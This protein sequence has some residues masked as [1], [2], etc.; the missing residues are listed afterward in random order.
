MGF[1]HFIDPYNGGGYVSDF[2]EAIYYGN[3]DLAKSLLE[4]DE[5]LKNDEFA[6]R[7]AIKGRHKEIFA[8]LVKLGIRIREIDYFE[9]FSTDES[10]LQFLPERQDLI[11]DL[12]LHRLNEMLIEAI[13]TE[14]V[15]SSR[16]VEILKEGAE[17]NYK[18]ASGKYIYN[19]FTPLHIAA[20]LA[21]FELVELLLNSGADPNI[22]SPQGCN[23]LRLILENTQSTKSLRKKSIH[24]FRRF[25]SKPKPELTILDKV[26]LFFGKPIKK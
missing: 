18:S 11:Q 10:Y 12:K 20:N 22:L 6:L 17:I 26:N 24:L 19:H 5:A 23:A 15:N 2:A 1:L 21:K 3:A 8:E 9:A 7:M 14:N 16:I 25:D 13:L 4:N